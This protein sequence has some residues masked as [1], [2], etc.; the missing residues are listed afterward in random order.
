MISCTVR[1][2]AR[3]VAL[4]LAI[5][6]FAVLSPATFAKE[7]KLG[8]FLPPRHT[9]HT[10]V[11]QPW[12]SEVAKRSGGDLKIQIY[13]ARQLGDTPVT[14]PCLRRCRSHQHLI[15]PGKQVEGPAEARLHGCQRDVLPPCDLSGTDPLEVA[16]EERR[17]EGL[18]ELNA[19]KVSAAPSVA[20]SSSSSCIAKDTVNVIV[21]D[22]SVSDS[23]LNSWSPNLKVL[24]IVSDPERSDS[25]SSECR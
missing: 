7:L 11:M 12:A 2:S 21:P 18:V 15:G 6:M 14:G 24:S 20:Y 9:N 10:K 5:G 19:Q 8:H 17:A 23:L 4:I 1:A 16:Q 13:P 25:I 3:W 22:T